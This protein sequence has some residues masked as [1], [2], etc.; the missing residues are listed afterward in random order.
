MILVILGLPLALQIGQCGG[1]QRYFGVVATANDVRRR[2][3]VLQH[4]LR[5][6]YRCDLAGAHCRDVPHR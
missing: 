4:K 2:S 6:R 3:T 1:R 5:A